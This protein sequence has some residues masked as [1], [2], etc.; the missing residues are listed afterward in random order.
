MEKTN[1]VIEL[2]CNFGDTVWALDSYC[3]DCFEQNDY[4]HRGCKKPKYRL[5]KHIVRRFDVSENGIYICSFDRYE[6]YGKLGEDIFLTFEEAKVALEKANAIE[7][8]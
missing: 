4:C 2:P 5:Q 1:P 3:I 6:M 8:Q 7:A